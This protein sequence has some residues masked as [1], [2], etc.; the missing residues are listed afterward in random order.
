MIADLDSEQFTVR[1]KAM[2]QLR[3]LDERAEPTLREALKDKLT[4]ETRKRI[5]ELLEGVRASAASPQRL[6]DLRAIEVLEYLGTA[7]ARQVLQTLADGAAHSR[8]TRE[9]KASL[10]RLLPRRTPTPK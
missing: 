4:L 10:D 1:E 8:L 6:R 9:A 7:D 3:Q 5:E 2:E